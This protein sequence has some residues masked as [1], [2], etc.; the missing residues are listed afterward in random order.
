[1]MHYKVRTDEVRTLSKISHVTLLSTID[2]FIK[3]VTMT[4]TTSQHS[5]LM[6]ESMT[7]L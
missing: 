6:I 4:V 1:M 5:M 3:K 2:F 7:S